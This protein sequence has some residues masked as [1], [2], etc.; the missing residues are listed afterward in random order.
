M[1]VDISRETSGVNLP[2]ELSQQILGDAVEASVV[3]RLGRQVRLPGGGT[4]MHKIGSEPVAEWVG[5]TDAKPV[6]SHTL[7]NLMMTPY[8]LAVIEAFSDEFRRDLRALYVELARRLP[9]SLGLEF[10]KT[11]F[12]ATSAPNSGTNF[13]QLS[14]ST[15]TE[16]IDDLTPLEDLVEI[17]QAA[18]AAG[19]DVSAWAASPTLVGMLIAANAGS[20][21]FD[22]TSNAQVGS[23]FG[24]PVVRTK[25]A[26]ASGVIGYAGD[27]AAD[28]MWGTVEGVKVSISDQATINSGGTP[29]N[30]WEQNM[31]A[32]RAE[33]EVGFRATDVN[34]FVK[35]TGGVGS[36]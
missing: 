2:P 23:V 11:V 34:R 24:A 36:S 22:L 10:D 13:D 27:F 9:Y 15:T 3:M 7:S 8:K 12:G 21:N 1:A 6:D 18:V 28:A 32:V 30:L 29:I 26:M 14:S 25:A 35:I 19:G 17:Y 5:E 16:S 31:F 20:A 4:V 33:I